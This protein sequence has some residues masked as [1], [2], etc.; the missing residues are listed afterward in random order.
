MVGEDVAQRLAR[1]K[2]VPP[3]RCSSASTRSA[4]LPGAAAASL[5]TRAPRSMRGQPARRADRRRPARHARSG[6]GAGGAGRPAGPEDHL[7]RRG[8]RRRSRSGTGR[9]A[10]ESGKQLGREGKR[11]AVEV[12]RATH[13]GA[14]L[15]VG[16]IVPQRGPRGALGGQLELLRVHPEDDDR[17]SPRCSAPPPPGRRSGTRL[18]PARRSRSGSRRRR[19]AG[20]PP[21]MDRRS[22]RSHRGRATR[23]GRR[24]RRREPRRRARRRRR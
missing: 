6:G 5:T 8:G 19:R 23:R 9:P 1:M 3:L 21:T 7:G 14:D 13:V 24:A 17:C 20:C 12:D 15:R 16:E 11:G 2:P 10:P 22:G 18:G 4:G